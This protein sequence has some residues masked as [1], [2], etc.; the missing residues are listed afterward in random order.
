MYPLRI[1][2][3]IICGSALTGTSPPRATFPFLSNHANFTDLERLSPS[4]H[5]ATPKRIS[6]LLF[7]IAFLCHFLSLSYIIPYFFFG[8]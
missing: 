8:S 5:E 7:I 3:S 4:S 6:Q 1:A 2:K